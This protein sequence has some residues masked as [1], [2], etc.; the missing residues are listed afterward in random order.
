MGDAPVRHVPV[1]V[2][3][4][5]LEAVQRDIAWREAEADGGGD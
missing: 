5:I 2:R 3:E 4:D 1:L